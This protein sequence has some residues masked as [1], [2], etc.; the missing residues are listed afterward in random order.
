MIHVWYSAFL[1]SSDMAILQDRIRPLIED[2]CRKIQ[3]KSSDNF[4]GKTWK[5]AHHS[6]RVELKKESWGK[7]LS[8]LDNV[9]SL[10]AERANQRRTAITLAPERVD[11]RDWSFLTLTPTHR[12]C[13]Q[14]FREDGVLLPFGASRHEFK[15]PIP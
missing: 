15:I 4:L 14:R 13:E 9:Q 7:V 8:Y 1:R 10:S 3:D 2:V 6:C 5:L 12:I 11:Y